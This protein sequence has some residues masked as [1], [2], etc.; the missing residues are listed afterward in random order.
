MNQKIPLALR[1]KKE[2]HRRI[3]EAQDLILKEVYEI[4]DNAVLHGGTAIW[5]CYSG[6]R[7]SE[8]LDFYI[9]RNTGKIDQLFTALEKKGFK[10]L[11]KKVLDRS[12]YSEL[13]F[14]RVNVR[15]EATFQNI[16]GS[17]INYEN[18]D[19]TFA[20][21]YSLTV[22][23]FI[24]EKVNTYLNRRKIKDL[25]DIFFL[26]K[27]VNNS[28]IADD[29]KRI[30]KNYQAPVDEQNLKTIILE[31]IV[32]RSQEIM[33]YLKQKWQKKNI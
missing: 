27:T 32:P 14:N 8:D 17:L 18:T 5:R 23:E 22:E 12:I 13:E 25:Y 7:F 1:I 9:V 26:A 29:V 21:I 20:T 31:G 24:K 3:A 10:I 30:I 2:S 19:G 28:K 4:F 11:K 33:E 15:F 6:K 16:K